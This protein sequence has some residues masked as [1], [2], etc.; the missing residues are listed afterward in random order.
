MR[1][2]AVLLS[3][4]VSSLASAHSYDWSVTQSY[5]NKIFI[6]HPNCEPQQMRWSQQECSNFRARAMTRFLKEWDDRQYLRSGK[7]VDNPAAT[8]RV[9]SELP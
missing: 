6:N 4:L 5:F 3:L 2:E 7:I 1:K 9:N 8:A